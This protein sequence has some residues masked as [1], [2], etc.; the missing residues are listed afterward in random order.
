[1]SDD[2]D[3]QSDVSAGDNFF[4]EESLDSNSS[5]SGEDMPLTPPAG[6]DMYERYFGG[7]A[8]KGTVEKSSE[9]SPPRV[10]SPGSPSNPK[11]RSV[12]GPSSDMLAPVVK[13]SH[14]LN[15]IVLNHQTS[16]LAIGWELGSWD[17]LKTFQPSDVISA[18]DGD[19]QETKLETD[20]Y[21]DLE[22][23]VVR[24]GK[25]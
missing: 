14:E 18:D 10:N 4:E 9:A 24:K 19:E 21:E 8:W 16:A 17:S 1:M 15:D 25:S 23:S 6:N 22:T 7:R 20:Y 13:V 2:S 11:S 12:F 3:T 5:D